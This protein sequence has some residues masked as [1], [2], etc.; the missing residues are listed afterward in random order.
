MTGSRITGLTF[1]V[2]LVFAEDPNNAGTWIA[3]ASDYSL[4]VDD[5]QFIPSGA[6]AAGETLCGVGCTDMLTD[7]M[8]C[9][10]CGNVCSAAR[11]CVSGVCECPAGY[12]DCDGE[13]VDLQTNAQNCGACGT[14]C[15]GQCSG[16]S[17]AA[18]S[19]TAGMTP[20]NQTA[21]AYEQIF[22]GKY[23][24]NNNQ[25]GASEVSG[26]QSVWETCLDGNTI[27]W[28]TEWDWPM[29][30]GGVKSH[31]SGVLGW[32]W[33]W[34]EDNGNTT[35]SGLARQLSSNPSITCGWT[36]TVDAGGGVMNVAYDLWTHS[37][38]HP[39]YQ[40]TPSH[41][42]M[43][44]LYSAG[45]AGPIGSPTATGLSIDGTVYTL[46]E[47]NNGVNAVHSFIRDNPS[48]T[49]DTIDIM[50]FMDDLIARGSVDA[51]QYL[52]SIQ[53]GTEVFSGAGRLDT[54]AYY[55]TIQ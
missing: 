31:A 41:E 46:W 30:S 37:T 13:C 36:Y 6:C 54:S 38:E 45:G 53:A 3:T 25:W 50:S 5:I 1:N 47:G 24:V 8:N 51:S 9:G 42:I 2:P 29:G 12:T 39:D 11:T 15:S 18:S 26:T 19:C 16:G 49:G 14:P 17:C 43:I 21:V 48:A 44:W 10:E 27:G 55:C 23:W 32:H 40:G 20:A 7:A 34:E 28:G 52:T 22:L 35:S 33:G 4:S